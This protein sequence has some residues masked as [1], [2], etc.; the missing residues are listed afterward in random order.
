ML[1]TF[2]VRYVG[3]KALA[4]TIAARFVLPNGDWVGTFFP[5]ANGNDNAVIGGEAARDFLLE[6]CELAYVVN[7]VQKNYDIRSI[8]CCCFIFVY[9]SYQFSCLSFNQHC[10][11]GANWLAVS[12][13]DSFV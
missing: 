12:V 11:I 5:S 9:I 1:N 7:S 13:D 8:R 10:A 4:S 2:F 6:R 3:L